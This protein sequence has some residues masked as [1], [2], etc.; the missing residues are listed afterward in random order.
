MNV[1]NIIKKNFMKE[2]PFALAMPALIWQVFFVFAPLLFILIM[3]FLVNTDSGLAI[4]FSYYQSLMNFTTIKIIASSLVLAILTTSLCLTLAYPIAYFLAFKAGYL[5]NVLL[6]F[7]VIPFWGNLLILVYAWFFILEKNGFLNNFLV[8][9]GLIKHPF[10]LLNSIS[11]IL[12]VMVYCYLP[13]MILPIF[14]I[15]EKLD[16]KLIEA[17]LDLGASYRQTLFNVI[18]PLSYPG[19]K[20]G[21]LFVFIVSFGEFVV[22]LLMGG[23]KYMFVGNAISHYI[24]V[25]SDISQ[26]ATFTCI[27]G[28][29]AIISLMIVHSMLRRALRG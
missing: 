16:I 4:N 17:S 11:A 19:I 6:F 15:L 8:H 29:A 27:S 5:K 24:F 1:L 12:I 2:M 28:V 18:L 21:F 26:G 14:S 22:P 7:L 23:D 9:V 10:M 20:T 3:S 25:A 13:F